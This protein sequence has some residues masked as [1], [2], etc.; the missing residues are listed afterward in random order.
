MVMSKCN[1]I[2]DKSVRVTSVADIPVAQLSYHLPGRGRD[3]WFSDHCG[4]QSQTIA[5]ESEGKMVLCDTK[6]V[7]AFG[8]N[9]L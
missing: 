4:L 7:V 6:N 9:I 2:L 8:F 3:L 5:A 1:N